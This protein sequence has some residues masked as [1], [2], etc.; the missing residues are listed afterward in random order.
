MLRCSF[1]KSHTYIMSPGLTLDEACI[2]I[3]G[4]GGQYLAFLSFSSGYRCDC[5]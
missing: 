3:N 2:D 5:H 4:D 1:I